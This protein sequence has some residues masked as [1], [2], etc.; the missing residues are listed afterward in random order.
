[1]DFVDLF[2]WCLRGNP[3]AFPELAQVGVGGGASSC[4][5]EFLT[6]GSSGFSTAAIPLVLL[7]SWREEVV[8]P[9]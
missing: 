7:N 2:A 6:V 3:G 8:E 9:H 4:R 5:P 1:M